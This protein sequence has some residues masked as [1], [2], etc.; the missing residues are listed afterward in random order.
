MRDKTAF[1]AVDD[2]CYRALAATKIENPVV[3]PC[4]H[5]EQDWAAVQ[6]L[7]LASIGQMEYWIAV[8]WHTTNLQSKK[9]LN[10]TLTRCAFTSIRNVDDWFADRDRA[11]QE[12]ER[13]VE[14]QV[15]PR[16]QGEG[17]DIEIVEI[18]DKRVYCRLQGVCA[19]CAGARQTLRFVVEDALQ[20]SVDPQIEV[21]PV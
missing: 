7:T 2:D 17:G 13:V 21:I 11:Q 3:T 10:S 16:L 20:A 8:D 15:R 6:P 19:T 4:S 18:R 1:K 14:N 9:E 5:N 12:I